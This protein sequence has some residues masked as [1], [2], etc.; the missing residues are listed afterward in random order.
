MAEPKALYM[1]AHIFLCMGN[2]TLSVP[3]D[4]FAQMKHFSEVKWSEVARKAIIEKI[5]TF[6]LADRLAKKGRL[7]KKDVEQFSQKI[8]SA[9]NKRFLA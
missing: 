6:Q 9:A 7:T 8:K 4:V 2:I 3:N 1:C 5:E